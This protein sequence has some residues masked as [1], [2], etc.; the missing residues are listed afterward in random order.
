MDAALLVATKRIQGGSQITP[1]SYGIE[2]LPKA[3]KIT[4]NRGNYHA[5]NP[6]QIVF[7]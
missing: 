4:A 2:D 6:P 1:V 7:A 5:S 3:M